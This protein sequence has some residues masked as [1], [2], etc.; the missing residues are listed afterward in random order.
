MLW[1][2]SRTELQGATVILTYHSVVATLADIDSKYTVSRDQLRSHVD[3]FIAAGW[4]PT[5]LSDALA[6]ASNERRFVVTFDDGYLDNYSVALPVLQEYKIRAAFFLVA[7]ALGRGNTSIFDGLGK[8]AFMAPEHVRELMAD[9]MTVGSHGKTHKRLTE[10]HADELGGELALSRIMLEEQ[11]GVRLEHFAYPFGSV[12]EQAREAVAAAGYRWA[13]TTRPTY[14]HTIA[15][16]FRIG[17]ITVCCDDTPAMLWR[18][19]LLQ[20]PDG[21]FVDV[22]GYFVRRFKRK[23]IRAKNAA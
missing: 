23:F 22:C 12:D 8:R 20:E 2:R 16:P 14:W 17:R 19:L 5:A 1:V 4:K 11:L 10:L 15:D 13:F 3:C 21:K 6:A 7:D 18:K 9:G